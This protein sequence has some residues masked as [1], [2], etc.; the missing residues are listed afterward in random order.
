MVAYSKTCCLHELNYIYINLRAG[1]LFFV[2]APHSYSALILA[3]LLRDKYYD[4]ESTE[5]FLAN[6]SRL[7]S[8]AGF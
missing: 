1:C 6:K 7:E 5:R 8:G 2:N 4:Q 3:V